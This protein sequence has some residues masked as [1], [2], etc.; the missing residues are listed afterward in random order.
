MVEE[1]VEAVLEDVSGWLRM[2]IWV[3][4]VKCSGQHKKQD[5]GI[6]EANIAPEEPE[7]AISTRDR[8][9]YCVLEVVD[10]GQEGSAG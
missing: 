5:D 4:F 7:R 2:D 8:P 6:E 1:G 9:T 10:R 3:V